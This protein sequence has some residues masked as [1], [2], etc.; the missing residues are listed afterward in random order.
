MSD[1]LLEIDRLSVDYQT[2]KGDLKALRDITFDVG[3]GEMS[4]LSVR[5]DAENPP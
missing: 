2:A 3:K 1:A 5:A 4:A